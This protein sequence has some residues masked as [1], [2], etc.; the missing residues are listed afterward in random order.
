MGDSFREDAFY[1]PPSDDRTVGEGSPLAG[2][3]GAYI[4]QT[5]GNFTL[6]GGVVPEGATSAMGGLSTN[7]QARK[8]ERS[9][10]VG[11]ARNIFSDDIIFTATQ[12]D[13]N[14]GGGVPRF[15]V[16]AVNSGVRN[17]L[18][19]TTN[20]IVTARSAELLAL[21]G[22]ISVGVAYKRPSGVLTVGPNPGLRQSRGLPQYVNT[23]LMFKSR[24]PR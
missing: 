11:I 5:N 3:D 16:S 10:L 24:R 7:Y 15:K 17:S 8:N 12:I 21:D 4:S 23:Y 14:G 1:A 6:K 18:D 20:P 2:P 22:S 9:Q 19:G 13:D